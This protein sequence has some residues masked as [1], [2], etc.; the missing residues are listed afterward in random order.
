MNYLNALKTSLVLVVFSLLVPTAQSQNLYQIPDDEMHWVQGSDISESSS[1]RTPADFVEGATRSANFV[2]LNE[3]NLNIPAWMIPALY[4]S[5]DIWSSQI[6]SSWPIYVEVEGQYEENTNFLVGGGQYWLVHDFGA[7]EPETYYPLAL[8]EAVAGEEIIGSDIPDIKIV[9]NTNPDVFWYFGLDANPAANEKDLVSAL[10]NTIGHGLGIGARSY[11][12]LDGNGFIQLNNN[13]Y[14]SAWHYKIE[15]DFDE[16][17]LEFYAEGST[18][19]GEAL[20]GNDLIWEGPFGN[21]ANGEPLKIYAP[22]T[23]IFGFSTEYL[24]EVAY[25]AGHPNSLMTPWFSSGEAIHDPGQAIL[26]MLKDLGWQVPAFCPQWYIPYDFEAADTPMIFACTDEVPAGYFL[27]DQNC[28]Q[29]V[30][31]QDPFCVEEDWDLQCQFLY[32]ACIYGIELACDPIWYIPDQVGAGP[33]VFACEAPPGYSAANA[34]CAQQIV[35]NDSFCVEDNWD[36]VCLSAY[37]CCLGNEACTDPDACNFDA[38]PFIC[39]NP[40][41]CTYPSCLDDVA[42]NYDPSGV[43]GDPA[44]CEYPGCTNAFA[45]N[46]DSQ[47][48]CD[49]GSCIVSEIYLPVELGN[50]VS[51]ACERPID[52]Y[53]AANQDC[54][55][56]VIEE[57]DGFCAIEWSQGCQEEYDCCV[58][59]AGCT[60]PTACNYD[61]DACTNDGSCLISDCVY[62]EAINYN[63]QAS[64]DNGSCVFPPFDGGSC[65][66]DINGDGGIDSAD[67]L[68]ILGVFG[69]SCP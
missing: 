19:L 38:T 62:E 41:L 6:E 14:L 47:A 48:G 56:Y 66:G 42:C 39:S 51:F 46:Y 25:S 12:D 10:L 5:L 18:A 8:A 20:T 57:I 52:Y 26:G 45:C 60:D 69:G 49:D 63:P 30:F 3:N 43:C 22:S 54:A 35:S 55:A 13:P 2:V 11:V 15:T 21:Q 61:E 27:A 40:D 23:H 1:I 4:Y 44:L 64:C 36:A 58:G 65:L 34:N 53:L 50:Q 17:P 68:I 7:G 32:N 67:L 31:L 16:L 28:A 59:G 24:D 33:A 37:N 9:I 29:S